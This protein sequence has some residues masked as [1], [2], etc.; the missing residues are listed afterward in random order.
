M[1]EKLFQT[2]DLNLLERIAPPNQISVEKI[3]NEILEQEKSVSISDYKVMQNQ[4]KYKLGIPDREKNIF[5]SIYLYSR[6]GNTDKMDYTLLKEQL[7]SLSNSTPAYFIYFAPNATDTNVE[8]LSNDLMEKISTAIA[9][10][11]Q[12]RYDELFPEDK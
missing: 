9:E 4:A 10:K 12:E 8:E 2:K 11:V 1:F 7:V 5:D 3:I 6:D